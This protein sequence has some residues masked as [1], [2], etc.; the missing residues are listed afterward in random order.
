MAEAI[1]GRVTLEGNRQRSLMVAAVEMAVG[2][3]PA[4]VLARTHQLR[5]VYR[6][7]LWRVHHLA[8]S[9]N[10]CRVDI[11]SRSSVQVSPWRFLSM[12]RA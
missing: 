4:A 8:A 7:D 12:R 1:A 5:L 11:Q 9:V 2:T 10:C 3:Q 6:H